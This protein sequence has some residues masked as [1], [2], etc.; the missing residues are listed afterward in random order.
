M[1]KSF[2]FIAMKR[3]LEFL[4][5][6]SG[7]IQVSDMTNSFFLVRFASNDDYAR[8]AFE[9]P[10]KIYDYYIAVSQWSP[11]FNEDEPIKSILTWVRLPKLPIHYFN[12]LAVS[13]IG[14]FIGK[15]VKLDLATSEGA[16]CRYARVCVEVDLTK[17]LLGKYMI[18][19][20]VLKIE[21]E[22]LE[23][24]CFDCG[25]YGHK[26]GDCPQV[27]NDSEVE[28]VTPTAEESTPVSEDQVTG[29]WM[30]VQRR[31]RKKP[32]KGHAHP[33]QK[34]ENG[35]RFS[36]LQAETVTASN[37]A[38]MGTKD[39]PG[40]Q[41]GVSEEDSQLAKL[42]KVLDEALRSQ[43]VADKTKAA[44]QG[45]KKLDKR[46]VLKDVS[47]NATSSQSKKA[48]IASEK[49]PIVKH[50]LLEPEEGLIPVEVVYQNPM[51]HS[52][53]STP[54]PAK[55]KSKASLKGNGQKLKVPDQTLN[56]LGN[57]KR[58]L[59]KDALSSGPKSSGSDQDAIIGSHTGDTRKPPDRS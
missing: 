27:S 23:N 26:I 8:A 32:I 11:S 40:S 55:A 41:S 4:W 18:E 58:S 48:S 57:K 44:P 19:D 54:K 14:N 10:W 49:T 7:A 37:P 17:P 6:R 50:G 29:E 43:E 34:I 42:K 13:R 1:E 31:N 16:R 28:K 45:V 2:S 15:T 21:Y 51:F 53:V 24:V 59:K 38:Q 30:T 5:A 33:N 56:L 25:C 22:S 52:L 36:V 12:S 46:E 9:G 3:R 47:N 20:R 35:S 39:Q